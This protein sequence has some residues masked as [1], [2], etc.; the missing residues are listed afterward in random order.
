[1]DTFA[2]T[3]IVLN[4]YCINS[5]DKEIPIGTIREGDI[6]NE[7]SRELHRLLPDKIKKIMREKASISIGQ[8]FCVLTLSQI[9]SHF[10]DDKNAIMPFITYFTKNV[11]NKPVSYTHLTLPTKRI[12]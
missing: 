6:S 3:K 4:D 1:M 5:S 7:V 10:S 11:V 12:V 8:K 9:L 2:P